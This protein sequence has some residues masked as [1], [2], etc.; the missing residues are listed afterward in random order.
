MQDAEQLLEF[1]ASPLGQVA[2]RVIAA[3]IRSRW[4][5]VARMDIVGLGYAAPY[6]R[7][8]QAEARS[9]AAL[10][11]R[12]Q[13]VVQWPREGPYRAALVVETQLPLPDASAH[14]VLAVHSLEHVERRNAYLRE[15]WR[16]L[17]PEGRFILVVPNRRGAWARR[18]NTPFGHG[19]TYS[20]RQIEK[21]LRGALFEPVGIVPCLFIPP[22]R[23]RAIS[24]AALIWE[25]LGVRLWPAL[26]GVI[27]IEAVK[28]VQAGIRVPVKRP[29]FAPVRALGG[30]RQS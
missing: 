3:R 6:L 23:F 12:R 21:L 22:V 19:R 29:V 13:G 5:N 24:R 26:S 18:D 8:F 11:P 15:I 4:T 2:R 20:P 27:I 9:V 30:L 28:R 16:V 1:Y 7:M 14:F 10:M 17:A 25:R